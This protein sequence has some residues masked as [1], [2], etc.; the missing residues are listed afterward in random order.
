[1]EDVKWSIQEEHHRPLPADTRQT[2]AGTLCEYR[3]GTRGKL[4]RHANGYKLHLE[5]SLK[6][7]DVDDET[8][9]KQSSDPY[10]F[11]D[12]D[13]IKLDRKIVIVQ[14]EREESIAQM[15][16]DR[17]VVI[18]E[19]SMEASIQTEV[20][21]ESTEIQMEESIVGKLTVEIEEREEDFQP[22][23]ES[24]VFKDSGTQTE[25][26]DILKDMQRRTRELEG[27]VARLREELKSAKEEIEDEVRAC[28]HRSC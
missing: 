11:T 19:E 28:V 3:A 10:V 22:V 5:L 26:H 7:P 24:E 15:P 20:E 12:R 27:Y 2:R 4:E 17:I 25:Y 21:E 9:F 18:E 1:V 13:I 23:Y 6:I 8:Y 14:T 16:E